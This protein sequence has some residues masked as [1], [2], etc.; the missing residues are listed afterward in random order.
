M[1]TVES[2]VEGK[3]FPMTVITPV[4]RWK[5]WILPLILWGFRLTKLND[6]ANLRSIHFAR[7]AIIKPSAFAKVDP[8]EVVRRDHF[9]F[10]TNFNGARGTST[11]MHSVWLARCG[12]A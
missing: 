1:A 12:A 9:L 8:V 10:S 6:V 4:S 5:R 3:T 11:S 7:W 2:K